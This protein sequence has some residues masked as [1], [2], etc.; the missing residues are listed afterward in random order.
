MKIARI[1]CLLGCYQYGGQ[2][3]LTGSVQDGAFRFVGKHVLSGEF[4]GRQLRYAPEVKAVHLGACLTMAGGVP[5][6][7]RKACGRPVPVSGF[8]RVA[9]WAGSAVIDFSYLDLV[10][11]RGIAPGEAVRQVRR[12]MSF[13]GEEEL[14]DVAIRPAGLKI[15]E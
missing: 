13:A 2:S 12:S 8:T 15:V 3:E 5:E 7:L 4:I 1:F 10:L 6:A 9:D 14:A 11:S